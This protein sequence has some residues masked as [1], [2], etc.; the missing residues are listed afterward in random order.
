MV[1][2][3]TDEM[4]NILRSGHGYSPDDV[5][6]VLDQLISAGLDTVTENEA[7]GYTFTVDELRTALLQLIARVPMA[8][9]SWLWRHAY[10]YA[11]VVHHMYADE[12]EAYAEWFTLRYADPLTL[13]TAI[14]H[15]REV[16]VWRATVPT[17]VTLG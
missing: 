6:S 7:S 5:T 4:I 12:C 13:T 17:M 9:Q 10:Y 2:Y 3:S 1:S 15:S 8:L 14:C 16:P 11:E